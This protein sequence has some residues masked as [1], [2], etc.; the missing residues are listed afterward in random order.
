[1]GRS[2]SV[3]QLY[4]NAERL[5]QDFSLFPRRETSAVIQGALT[6]RDIEIQ[7]DR[8]RNMDVD[9]YIAATVAPCEEASRPG[10]RDIIRD[11]DVPIVNEISD[12]PFYA[13]ECEFDFFGTPRMIGIIAQDRS[14]ASG[15]CGPEH[16]EGTVDLQLGGECGAD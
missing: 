2:P 16:H 11:L 13:V 3:D 15:V 7:V 10:A 14:H 12:G 9:A 5:A 4:V 8:L 1:M 6:D